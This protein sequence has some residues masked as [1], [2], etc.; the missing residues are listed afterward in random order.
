MPQ[1]EEGHALR[2][3]LCHVQI[4]KTGTNTVRSLLADT[5]PARKMLAFKLPDREIEG[6]ILTCAS[7]DPPVVQFMEALRSRDQEIDMVSVMAP[8]GI[9]RLVD[10]PTRYFSFV[11]DPVARCVSAINFVFNRG[12]AH[13]VAKQYAALGW[14]IERIVA[15]G[16]IEYHNDQVRMLSGSAKLVMDEADLDLAKANIREHCSLVGTTESFTRDWE[17]LALHHGFLADPSRKANEGDYTSGLR[18]G[19]LDLEAL[20]EANALD[21][22]LIQWVRDVY[23]CGIHGRGR[24]S[25]VEPA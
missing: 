7:L 5:Y 25:S 23:L 15:S 3:L 22:R 6:R 1:R 24:R 17:W 4:A 20:E 2:T 13:P 12:A 14:S 11:R 19:K 8:F 18:V 10:R 9:H 21:R 16:D